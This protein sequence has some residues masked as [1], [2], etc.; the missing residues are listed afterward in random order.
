MLDA[1]G[2]GR[3]PLEEAEKAAKMHKLPLL[4]IIEGV[5]KLADVNND[6]VL[7]L[8]E[9]KAFSSKNIMGKSGSSAEETGSTTPGTILG[10]VDTNGDGAISSP[11]LRVFVAQFED[12]DTEKADALFHS[13]DANK[14][15]RIDGDE[16]IP[17]HAK[18]AEMIRSPIPGGVIPNARTL[19]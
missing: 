4:S 16:L 11:E 5:F 8:D 1:N 3:L 12:M 10:V 9:F 19:T 18:L 14:D 6:G 7:S 17:L 13:I 2:D 15:G